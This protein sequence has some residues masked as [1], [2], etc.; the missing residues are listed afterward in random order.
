MEELI[1][2]SWYDESFLCACCAYVQ[3]GHTTLSWYMALYSLYLIKSQ[4]SKV[5]PDYGTEYFF[6]FS[7]TE[8]G[9]FLILSIPHAAEHRAL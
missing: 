8:M 3:Q 2:L 5:Y 6:V 1:P 9:I 4:N 7:T